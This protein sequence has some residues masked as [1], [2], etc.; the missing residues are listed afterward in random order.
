MST[1]SLPAPPRA[2]AAILEA[3]SDPDLELTQLGRVVSRDPSFAGLILQ[4]SNTARHRGNRTTP[5]T[6]L[7]Q[8]TMRLGVRAV[9]NYALC[10]AARSCVS[11]RKL[12][13]FD[14]DQFWEDSVRRAVA[15][16]LLAEVVEHNVDPNG[17]FTVGL[18][19]ELGVIALIV[20]APH[21][22]DAWTRVCHAEPAARME[23]ERELFGVD[24]TEVNRGLAS[25]WQ[26]PD[27]IARPMTHHHAPADAPP[28]H[29]VLSAIAG[30]AEALAMVLASTDKRAALMRARQHLE[31]LGVGADRLEPLVEQLGER[32]SEVGNSM[33][34][35]VGKQPTLEDI[36]QEANRSLVEA[37]LSYEELVQRLE[38]T[39]EEK[40]ALN[41][42]LERLSTTDTLTQLPNRRQ[43][44][45]RLTEE[46]SRV[47]RHGG[48]VSLVTIDI[49]H[50]KSVND[51]WG[52]VFGDEVL[53]AVAA[54]L[55][56][57]AR[58]NDIVARTGGEEFT[59]LLPETG[60]SGASAVAQ[61]MLS[62]VAALS[63]SGPGGEAIRVT[64]SLG[65][66]WLEGPHPG[67]IN[68]DRLSTRLYQLSD[69]ALYE[70]KQSG[71]NRVT[72]RR[73]MVPWVA[74]PEQVTS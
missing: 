18:L 37:N 55:A 50:F 1:P 36:L 62:R 63:L 45:R 16:E 27:E 46:L 15:A 30:A 71:R 54:A 9:R 38:Q 23:A 11:L 43:L 47:A 69:E 49:D 20:R 56:A 59:A 67:P 41:R 28:E 22:A 42:E 17:A 14:L 64:V 66:A 73:R 61:R 32:V 6:H 39:L 35:R 26:L 31:S 34:I 33:G 68:L 13:E 58:A 4:V 72:V 8:A 10:H 5:I 29:F 3:A 25:D 2:L 57:N 60:V 44:F 74:L 12:G 51:T 52:H 21:H 40:A 24:H 65:L 19:M 7:H 70:S 48:S 53:Q